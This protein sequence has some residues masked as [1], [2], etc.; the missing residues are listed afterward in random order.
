MKK[1]KYY[2]VVPVKLV[3]TLPHFN[4]MSKLPSKFSRILLIFRNARN[5][6]NVNGQT[7]TSE[8]LTQGT[9]AETAYGVGKN[10]LL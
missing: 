5:D 9:L 2:P 7:K 3:A 4:N 10:A 8:W 1:R 6:Y